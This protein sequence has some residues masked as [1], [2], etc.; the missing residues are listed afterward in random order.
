M[1]EGEIQYYK[2]TIN[3]EDETIAKVE[4]TLN[5]IS[6]QFSAFSSRKNEKPSVNDFDFAEFA[7]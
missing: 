5:A 7:S 6:G 2:F 1:D 4:F 3:Q